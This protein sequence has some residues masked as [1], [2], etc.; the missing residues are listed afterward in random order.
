[1]RSNGEG[2]GGLQQC[3]G[4]RKRR[5]KGREVLMKAFG[6]ELCLRHSVPVFCCVRLW[7]WTWKPNP[8]GHMKT[9]S[10]SVSIHHHPLSVLLSPA[11]T[12]MDK[13][14]SNC[15]LLLLSNFIFH[16]GAFCLASVSCNAPF[17]LVSISS[18]FP[19]LFFSV[20]SRL[21]QVRISA[22]K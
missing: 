17:F 8:A 15:L 9:Q 4:G 5:E 10:V 2:R 7:L 3:G 1:M 14:S 16:Q 21:F 22:Q 19:L 6:S 12:E 13:L 20:S 18:S 11:H